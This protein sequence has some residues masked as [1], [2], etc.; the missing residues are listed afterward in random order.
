MGDISKIAHF[1]TLILGLRQG[2]RLLSLHAKAQ[3]RLSASREAR[4]MAKMPFYGVI[5]AIFEDV[6]STWVIQ[7]KLR[8][9]LLFNNKQS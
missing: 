4:A 8:R 1:R 3:V 2:F 9:R 7:A 5:W 6:Q